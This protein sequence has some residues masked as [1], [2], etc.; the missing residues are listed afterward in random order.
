MLPMSMS[1]PLKRDALRKANPTVS[2]RLEEIIFK[3]MA[4]EPEQRYQSA[5]AMREAICPRRKFI[6]LPF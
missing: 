5:R 4:I 3:A 1:V 6:S 2:P